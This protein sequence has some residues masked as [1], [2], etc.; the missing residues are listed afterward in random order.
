[1]IYFLYGP[2]SY[3]LR[4]KL[5]EIIAKHGASF[6]VERALANELELGEITSRF[7]AN[8]LFAAKKF[9]VVEGV[10]GKSFKY[11]E[12][13]LKFLQNL[14]FPQDEFLIFVEEEADKRTS[15]F[16]YLEKN[17][18]ETYE[19]ETLKGSEMEAWLNKKIDELGLKISRGNTQKLSAA[20]LSD[21]W[22]AAQE[23]K[24]LS[25]Y[26]GDKEI[27]GDDI[28]A[29]VLGR[30]ADK[31]FE[32]TDAIAEKNKPAALALLKNQMAGDDNEIRLLSMIIRQFRIML[33]IKS[34]AEAG[35]QIDKYALGRSLGI[36]H[37][38]VQ[39]TLP[40]TKKYSFDELKKIYGQLLAIDIKMKSTSVSK[41]ALL[42][43]FVLEL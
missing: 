2:D 3:R 31:I 15:L 40:L 17:A 35:S 27:I 11:K 41:A 19:F 36:H 24:K 37:Y 14:N 6:E 33:Q 38:A 42:D 21:T 34:L 30:A 7:G 26:A 1:M 18:E 10:L 20:V 29:L 43:K 9:L 25:A 23:L 13:F 16:K 39:K 8:T 5:K 12:E 22:L 32:L 4:E 28:D